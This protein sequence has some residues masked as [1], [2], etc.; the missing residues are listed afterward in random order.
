MEVDAVSA[1]ESQLLE[2]FGEPDGDFDPSKAFDGEDIVTRIHAGGP[3]GGSVGGAEGGAGLD[4]LGPAARAAVSAAVAAAAGVSVVTPATGRPAQPIHAR[5]DKAA[6]V[7]GELNP[8]DAIEVLGELKNKA[9]ETWALVRFGA[10]VE[11]WLMVADVSGSR[12]VQPATAAVPTVHSVSHD[13]GIA[14]ER[15]NED[16]TDSHRVR[17]SINGEVI[18]EIAGGELVAVVGEAVPESPGSDRLWVPI[19]IPDAYEAWALH[20]CADEDDPTGQAVLEFLVPAAIKTL[21]DDDSLGKTFHLNARAVPSIVVRAAPSMAATVLGTLIPGEAILA[22][23]EV[24]DWLCLTNACGFRQ[25]WVRARDG[26]S[27][28]PTHSVI[29][30]DELAARRVG[31]EHVSFH[32]S[33]AYHDSRAGKSQAR[34]DAAIERLAAARTTDG[35]FAA[36]EMAQ[37]AV[38][39]MQRLVKADSG[40]C[41]VELGKIRANLLRVASTKGGGAWTIDVD[42]TFSEL[43]ESLTPVFASLEDEFW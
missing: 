14:W 38:N 19:A 26:P 16:V 24:D 20:C 9:G 36:L 10:A 30:L 5:P 43:L 40:L 33:D 37:D 28:S 35:L 18:G 29:P 6:A 23:M 8:R 42:A 4:G 3:S 17:A 13:G 15:V 12:K 7:I 25:G 32:A 41:I 2:A 27:D 34:F 21:R 39:E 31:K 1:A 11:A 22:T